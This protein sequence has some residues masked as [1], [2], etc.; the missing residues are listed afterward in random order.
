MHSAQAKA[1]GDAQAVVETLRTVRPIETGVGPEGCCG[2]LPD[3][4]GNGGVGCSGKHPKTILNLP[5]T[6]VRE[7]VRWTPEKFR[8]IQISLV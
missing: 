2:L 5:R 1:L 6:T 4:Y 3:G 7:E 8:G